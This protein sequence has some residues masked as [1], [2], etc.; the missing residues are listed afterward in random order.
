MKPKRRFLD[1]PPK[2]N[3]KF[4]KRFTILAMSLLSSFLNLYSQ[5]NT[6]VWS[7]EFNRTTVDG[8]KWQSISKNGC[9]SVCAFGNSAPQR[10]DPQQMETPNGLIKPQEYFGFIS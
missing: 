6:L 10:Y 2:N 1:Q 8:S 7:N 3:S 5:C 9:P 4:L